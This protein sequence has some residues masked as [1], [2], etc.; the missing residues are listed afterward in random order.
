[1]G[2]ETTLLTP[3][4]KAVKQDA[5]TGDFVEVGDVQLTPTG[6]FAAYATFQDDGSLYRIAGDQPLE[7]IQTPNLPGVFPPYSFAVHPEGQPRVLRRVPYAQANGPH[8]S[9]AARPDGRR[10][11][12]RERAEMTASAR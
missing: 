1:A 7:I 4:D 11:R 3:I 8:G 12:W 2:S 5:C 6:K 10:H 9:G